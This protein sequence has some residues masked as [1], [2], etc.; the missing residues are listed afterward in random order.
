MKDRTV[1]SRV[2][3]KVGSNFVEE[4]VKLLIINARDALRLAMMSFHAPPESLSAPRKPV[5]R[6]NKPL[7]LSPLRLWNI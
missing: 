6:W 4:S 5:E 1:G 7:N 3:R 2:P